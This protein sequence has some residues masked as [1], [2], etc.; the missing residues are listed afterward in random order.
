MLLR[1]G[2]IAIYEAFADYGSLPDNGDVDEGMSARRTSTL[3]IKFVKILSKVFEIQ[4]AEENE[5]SIIAEQKRISRTFVPFTSTIGAITFTGIF[6]TGD[7]PN[8]ILAT[9]KG[10]LRLY[11]SGHNVVHTFTACSLWE[12]K[13]EFLVYTDEV[14]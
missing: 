13:S 4:R 3:K 11:P 14:G 6:F 2:P 7:N 5:K 9:D 1:S 8:W 12:S 10:G